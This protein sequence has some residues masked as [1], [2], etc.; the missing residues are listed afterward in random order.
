M[1]N[2]DPFENELRGRAG[3]MRRTPS[4]Q[5]WNRIERKL[6]RRG[7]RNGALVFGLRPWMIAAMLLLVAGLVAI[8]TLDRPDASP[9]AQRSESIEDLDAAFAPADNFDAEAYR[10]WLLQSDAGTGDSTDSPS[11]FRDVTVNAKYRS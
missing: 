10:T 5:A 11:D 1:A 4:P 2:F 3:A 6:D 9:L 7:R 8:T